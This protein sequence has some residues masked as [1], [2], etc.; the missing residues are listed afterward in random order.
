MQKT[1]GFNHPNVY[2]ETKVTETKPG[3]GLCSFLWRSETYKDM[4]VNVDI[5]LAIEISNWTPQRVARS[6]RLHRELPSPFFVVIKPV[7]AMHRRREEDCESLLRFSVSNMEETIM[8]GL[9]DEIRKGFILM[10]ALVKSPF[11]PE[12]AVISS[13]DLR[14]LVYYCLEKQLEQLN[15][16]LWECDKETLVGIA[17][18]NTGIPCASL[19]WCKTFCIAAEDIS[20]GT[21]PR[22]I[23]FQFPLLSFMGC[24]AFCHFLAAL[25]DVIIDTHSI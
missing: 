22:D 20:E 23:I 19:A 5:V 16:T 8:R 6:S 18:A 7:S 15:S 25:L 13:F 9:P 11:F 24:S 4:Q 3:V 14:K 21:V 2:L 17:V 12:A 1:E 10:K